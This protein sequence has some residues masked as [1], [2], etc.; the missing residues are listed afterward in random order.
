MTLFVRQATV[1][2]KSPVDSISKTLY[3]NKKVRFY[4]RKEVWIPAG[5]YIKFKILGQDED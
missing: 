1:K 2:Y 4:I 5:F 3:S